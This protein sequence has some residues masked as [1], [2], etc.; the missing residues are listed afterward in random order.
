MSRDKTR[1]TGVHMM[2]TIKD[3]HKTETCPHFREDTYMPAR[4][5]PAATVKRQ[6]SKEVELVPEPKRNGG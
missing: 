4:K 1:K 5:K 3:G 6:P 2:Q